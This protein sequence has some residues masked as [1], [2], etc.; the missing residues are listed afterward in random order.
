MPAGW[1]EGS[2]TAISSS[3][4]LYGS[5]GYSMKSLTA[6]W[7]AKAAE[8]YS[9]AIGLLR[10]RKVPS[11]SICFHSQQAAEKLLKAV[12]QQRAIH[13]GKTHDLEGLLRLCSVEHPQLTLLGADV[14][15]LND[16]AV[17]Y[18][19][20]G[21]DATTKQARLAAKAAGRVRQAVLPLLRKS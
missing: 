11:D 8:D 3:K 15:L 9:V 18:R 2:K 7:M 10:R 12:L 17:R 14:Q 13:F 16:Y 6:E 1:L 5:A 20:P 21:I 19:Y 4:M